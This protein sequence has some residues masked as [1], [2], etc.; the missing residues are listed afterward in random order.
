MRDI[1]CKVEVGCTWVSQSI[2]F[3]FTVLFLGCVRDIM[4]NVVVGCT[5]V[6]FY[7]MYV[8]SSLFNLDV[9]L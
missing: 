4:S 8:S 5:W 3:F 6:S 2:S 7:S 9:E 1:I